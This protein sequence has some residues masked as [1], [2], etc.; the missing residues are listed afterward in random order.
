M[1]YRFVHLSLGYV[2]IMN[3]R[4]PSK[5]GLRESQSHC[6]QNDL[7]LPLFSCHADTV[8]FSPF[9]LRLFI[10]VWFSYAALWRENAQVRQRNGVPLLYIMHTVLHLCRLL[11]QSDQHANIFP[12][13]SIFFIFIIYSRFLGLLVVV[14]VI[15]SSIFVRQG[16]SS[17]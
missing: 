3:P 17:K 12:F 9:H 2:V 1:C 16:D 8:I 14:N 10:A 15:Q 11:W 4:W 7:M 13:D 5:K 6:F